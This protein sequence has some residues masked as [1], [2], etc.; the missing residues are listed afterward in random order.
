MLVVLFSV[1]LV[2]G[3][4]G[5]VVMK[6]ARYFEQYVS[7]EK[8]SSG[9]YALICPGVALFVFAN[10]VINP[11]LVGLGVMDKF[12]IA[13]FMA[14]LPLVAVQALTIKVYF[15]LNRKLIAPATHGDTGALAP[16][17]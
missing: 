7:G 2:F 13:Y 14:Y 16:A 12:S 5:Y 8:K 17:E 9:S 10:F 15:Q 3:F 6:R 4:I 11:G 1:Q